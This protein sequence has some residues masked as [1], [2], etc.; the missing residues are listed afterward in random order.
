[1]LKFFSSL[2]DF[3]LFFM[4]FMIGLLLIAVLREVGL[5][6]FVTG[7]DVPLI[8]QLAVMAFLI[9]GPLRLLERLRE[10]VRNKFKEENAG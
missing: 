3:V 8:P 4:A 5:D 6:I 9:W 7:T 10:W 1:M 2:K